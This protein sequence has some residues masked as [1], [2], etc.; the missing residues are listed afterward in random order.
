MSADKI[1]VLLLVLF[2]VGFVF[3]VG[4][5]SRQNEKKMKAAEKADAEKPGEVRSEPEPEKEPRR[6]KRKR[7]TP[8]A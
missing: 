7:G 8:V 4:W 3:Y 5:N 1:F 6:P 2:F